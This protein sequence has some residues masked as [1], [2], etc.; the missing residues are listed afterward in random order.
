MIMVA[1]ETDD[2]A[3][4]EGA[5]PA[6]APARPRR[7]RWLP[8]ALAH[9][10]AANPAIAS[11]TAAAEAAIVAMTTYDY[12]SVD[13]DFSWVDTSGT[14]GFRQDFAEASDPGEEAGRPAP[15]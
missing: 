15:D 5:E 10:R 14:P 2:E 11:A 9:A 6:D 1:M 13:E 3:F 12:R 8:S 4:G 7:L